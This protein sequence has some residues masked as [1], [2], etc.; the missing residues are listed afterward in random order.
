MRYGKIVVVLLTAVLL[1]A[2][3]LAFRQ[4]ARRDDADVFLSA[5]VW[6]GEA[7]EQVS[8]WQHP[9]GGYYIFLPGYARM[10]QVHLSCIDAQVWINGRPAQADLHC[11]ALELNREY[12]M[13]VKL[14]R[15]QL[16]STL[17]FVR[18]GGLPSLYV[19]VSSGSMEYIHLDKTNE[20]TGAMRLY[21]PAGEL[22]YNGELASVKGRGNTSWGAEKKPYNLT[23]SQ[24]ADLLGMG[25]AMRWI[26]LAEGHN[27]LNIR[28]K[29][30][31][32]FA[33]KAGLP[34]TPDCRWVD[35][36]LN[37]EYAGLYLLSERNEIHPHRVDIPMEGSFVVSLEM[38]ANLENQ[39]LPY[40][41]LQS[42]QALRL[43]NTTVDDVSMTQRWQSVEN[44]ILAEDGV[45][46]VTGR[47]Y[48]ELLDL[49]SWVRKYL[50][51]E[52]F[53]NPDGGAVSQ[54]FYYSA[55]DPEG[56]VYAGPVWDYDYALGGEGHW[57]RQYPSYRTL[58]REYTDDG[59]YLPWYYTLY[60]K[61]A[62]YKRLTE[63]YQEEFL[64]LLESLAQEG[65]DDYL[66]VIECA[67]EAD[68]IRWNNPENT[69]AAEGNFLKAFL[70]RRMAFLSDLWIEG[71]TYHTVHVEPG[72]YS[73]GYFAVKD[74]ECL[75]SL[76]DYREIGGIGWYDA[77]TD[78]PFDLSQPIHGDAHI[79]VKKP[80]NK[81]P[82]IH[83][84][85]ALALLLGIPMLL[86]ME[87]YRTK[88]NG[89]QRK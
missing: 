64:P 78:E 76:P 77:E 28:N 23:L 34:Y 29:I 63:L 88:K 44:A 11:G 56:R 40:I 58:A 33:K 19:D 13:T 49:D 72:R 83:Y 38:Q 14:G 79:Y 12:P 42:G 59:V 43:R 60:R 32:D 46:P 30:V 25:A 10:N 17:T 39:K 75:P 54:Y 45:D 27:P 31:Y 24:E 82:V 21:S 71:I 15:R 61:D 35:L 80:E 65:I 67:A 36:Y 22:L 47:H 1:V 73:S 7:M 85:P 87:A 86:A 84:L 52:V 4:E 57:M 6:S 70:E 26:L 55:A 5:S 8:C 62:F 20:E 16:E 9:E 3:L 81:L 74:G 51:E 66:S 37:G 53:A 48:Q 50:I 89:R 18:S 68:R 41:L 2:V 69:L